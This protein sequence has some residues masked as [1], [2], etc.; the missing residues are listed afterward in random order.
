MIRF[1]NC[2]LFLTIRQTKYIFYTNRH[3]SRVSVFYYVNMRKIVVTSGKGG[4][5]KTTVTATLGRKLA[6]GGY[7]VVLVDGDVG[8]NNLDVVT[9]IERRVVYD[10]GDV[11]S[12]RCRAFQALVCDSES[13]MKILPSSKDSTLLTAQAF[14]CVVDGFESTDFV[15]VDC[16]A[17]IEQGFHRAV[18]ACDEALV[19]TTPN[20]SAIRDADKVI[21]LLASYPLRDVSLV[22]N[23]VRPDMIARG[24]MLGASEI[25]ALLHVLPIGVIPEDDMI[26]LYQQ[27]GAVPE[28]AMSDRAFNALARNVA[29]CTKTFVDV[30]PKRRFLRFR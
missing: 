28:R 9:G 6:L 18:S 7:R 30:A 25:G 3:Y 22:V 27:L 13:P 12:G 20:A 10:I 26:T 23:R 4:V 21:R 14:R 11:L 8:L 15:I 2:L 5:G 17:G 19:V 24:E 29:D 1:W 16:P